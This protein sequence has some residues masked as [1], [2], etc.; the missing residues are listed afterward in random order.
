MKTRIQRWASLDPNTDNKLQDEAKKQG[1]SIANL[2]KYIITQYFMSPE[3]P[4]APGINV[5]KKDLDD[6]KEL[7]RIKKSANDTVDALNKSQKDEYKTK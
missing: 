7:D 2:L 3:H 4:N 5:E 1:R 6:P